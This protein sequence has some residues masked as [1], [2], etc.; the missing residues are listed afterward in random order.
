MIVDFTTQSKSFENAKIKSGVETR[1]FW[2]FWKFP[3][4]PGSLLDIS[5]KRYRATFFDDEMLIFSVQ[6][7][8]ILSRNILHHTIILLANP[9]L[10]IGFWTVF[11]RL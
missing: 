9:P 3:L 1:K 6:I 2:I 5:E 4:D 11:R 7:C 8:S 10:T